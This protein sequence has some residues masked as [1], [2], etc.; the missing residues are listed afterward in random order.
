MA[1]KQKTSSAWNYYSEKDRNPFAACLH[2]SAKIK[3]GKVGDKNTWFLNL[4]T[5]INLHH[6]SISII[7]VKAE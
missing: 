5:L 2:C 7:L 4:E 3:Q 6:V 1:S